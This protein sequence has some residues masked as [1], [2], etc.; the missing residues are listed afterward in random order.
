MVAAAIVGSVEGCVGAAILLLFMLMALFGP[1]LAHYDPTY[2]GSGPPDIGPSK[3]FLLG[4]DGLGRDVLS[5]LLYGAS[6]VIGTPLLAT[7]FS[8]AVGGLTGLVAGYMG[9]TF[10]GV[11]SRVIDILLSLPPLL[12]VLVIIAAFGSGTEVIVASVAAVY[13]PRVARILRGATQGVATREY[14]LAA[15]AR[16]ER[17]LPIVLREVLPNIAPTV[18]VEFAVRLTYVIIFITTLNFL[19]LGLHP[20]SPNWGLM[21]S[22]SRPTLLVNPVPTLAPTI[23][24]GTLCVS[25]G[26][27]ADAITRAY[28]IQKQ[29][30][31]LR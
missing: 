12:I 9:G 7:I 13:S 1:N 21:V 4:T 2:I 11:V 24:I 16:G 22:D 17:T 3:S 26:L 15:Q 5:R 31:L 10:D 14:I 29:S 30:D 25:I 28:G 19:G 27:I 6:S 23:A 8:F 20:P 18:L